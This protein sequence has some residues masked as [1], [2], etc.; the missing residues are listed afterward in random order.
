MPASPFPPEPSDDAL[1]EDGD[2]PSWIEDDATAADPRVVVASLEQSGERLDRFLASVFPALSRSRLKHLIEAGRVF[3]DGAMETSVSA[4]ARAG[5]TYE[6]RVPLPGPSDPDS[7]PQ[8]EDIP[9]DILFEDSHLIVLNKPA[10]LSCHPAPGHWSGTLVNAVLHHAGDSLLQ[11]GAAGRPGIVHRLDMDTSGVMVVAK[12]EFAMASLGRQ[13]QAR[14]VE[15]RYR[16]FAVGS[17]KAPFGLQGRIETRIARDPKDRKRM[18]V[19]AAHASAGKLAA[20]NYSVTERFGRLKEPPFGP[21]ACA[22]SCKLET[23]RTHQIRVHMAHAGAPLIGDTVYGATRPAKLLAQRLDPED[24]IAR[25]ALH[26]ATLAFTHPESG[27]RLSFATPL[28]DDMKRLAGA[29]RALQGGVAALRPVSEDD[30]FWDY[31]E[32]E[33]WDD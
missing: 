24:R 6:V 19:V 7:A 15:R 13:F 10:G 5:A 22:L 25:Q 27:E 1:S 31:D 9:L 14:T 29:L 18:S 12:S 11:V 21:E 2:E 23:G 17:P 28:P 3:R 16:A 26:A 20:T 32:D 33:D 4:K 8:P 30:G